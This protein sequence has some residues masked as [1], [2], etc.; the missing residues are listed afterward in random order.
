[1]WPMLVLE[2]LL[3]IELVVSM[4]ALELVMAVAR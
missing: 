3:F 2:N 1:M 4:A